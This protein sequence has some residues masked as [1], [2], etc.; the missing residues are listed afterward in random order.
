MGEGGEGG[1]CWSGKSPSSQ[2]LA[3]ASQPRLAPSESVTGDCPG[4]GAGASAPRE[5]S[6]RAVS[7][8]TRAAAVS[9]GCH[10]RLPDCLGARAAPGPSAGR[11]SGG[12]CRCLGRPCRRASAG[13]S[14]C[15]GGPRPV[16][17][18]PSSV[19]GGAGA[20]RATAVPSP[21]AACE[22]SLPS[23]PAGCRHPA[24]W[25]SRLVRSPLGPSRLRRL[26]ALASAVAAAAA[27]AAIASHGS[28]P[29]PAGR[30]EKHKTREH[31]NASRKRRANGTRLPL[32]QGPAEPG[33]LV[34]GAWNPGLRSTGIQDVRAGG[35]CVTWRPTQGGEWGW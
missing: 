27:A 20:R 24:A 15:L 30:S 35:F 16:L 17:V 21:L 18:A 32:T 5:R 1:G 22:V 11:C 7:R 9:H 29:R 26:A 6:F 28:H 34:R 14:R 12:S 8:A 4:A 10:A 2:L 31:A 3:A 33:P 23:V 25:P 19:H 13:S